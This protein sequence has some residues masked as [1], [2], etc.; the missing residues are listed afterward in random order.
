MCVCVCVC[1]QGVNDALG[2]AVDALQDAQQE[3]L[4]MPLEASA[5]A[6]AMQHLCL[7][8]L[9]TLIHEWTGQS[10]GMAVVLPGTSTGLAISINVMA[11][12]TLATMLRCLQVVAHGEQE[13]GPGLLRSAVCPWPRVHC[14]H[15]P[16][17]CRLRLQASTP[18]CPCWACG[19]S[20]AGSSPP[21]A[22]K[23]AAAVATG[24][25]ARG[26]SWSDGAGRGPPRLASSRAPFLAAT[27]EFMYTQSR[28]MLCWPAA[29]LEVAK[30]LAAA[31]GWLNWR[32]A[33]RSIL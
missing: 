15:P 17:G 2:Q 16:G 29:Q 23:A 25:A 4:L 32:T 31:A 1:V 14:S 30:A 21:I 8:K 28:I 6:L 3:F 22:T 5:G 24:G 26:G 11:S 33:V 20:S 9:N 12:L 7:A 13:L 10:F 19:A 27:R 18:S